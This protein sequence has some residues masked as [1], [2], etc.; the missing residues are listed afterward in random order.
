MCLKA[1]SNKRARGKEALWRSLSP[2][3]GRLRQEDKMATWRLT[4]TLSQN[5]KAVPIGTGR[6]FPALRRSCDG[7]G[8]IGARRPPPGAMCRLLWPWQVTS[9]SPRFATNLDSQSPQ[10]G[11]HSAPRGSLIA[12]HEGHRLQAAG[13]ISR[14]RSQL[15][16]SPPSGHLPHFRLLHWAGA[17]PGPL[18][19]SAT[20][21]CSCLASETLA[22]N[23]PHPARQPVSPTQLPVGAWH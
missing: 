7:S 5:P 8:A 18:H 3:P 4:E 1:F 23:V 16:L 10:K 21:G 15:C 11:P 2:A 12:F 13:D 19:C 22:D 9:L 20:A 17:A 14:L 6:V